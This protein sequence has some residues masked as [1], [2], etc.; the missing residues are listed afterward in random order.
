MVKKAKIE[1]GAILIFIMIIFL[2]LFFVTYPGDIEIV[3]DKTYGGLSNEDGW[4][5]LTNDGQGCL[6]AG[7]TESFG[8]GKKD[9]W[10]LK[11]D[12]NG[13]GIWN[14]TYG[15]EKS[16]TS[17]AIS[18][19]E[20]DSYLILGSTNSYGLEN[21][22]MWLIKI[23]EEGEEIWN[24]TYGNNGWEEGASIIQTEDEGYILVGSTSSYGAGSDDV[25]AIKI[26]S[27]GAEQWN[28]T[29]GGSQRDVGRSIDISEEGYAIGGT[30]SSYGAGQDDMWLIKIDKNGNEKWNKTFG[31]ENNERC[32]QVISTSNSIILVGHAIN[33]DNMWNAFVVNANLDGEQQW[34]KTIEKNEETGFSSCI[35]EENGYIIT[36]H[37]GSYGKQQ[38]LMLIYI[39]NS[40]NIIW[41]YI[42]DKDFGNAGV[43]IDN[44][45][46]SQFYVTG[47]SDNNGDESYDLWFLK[48]KI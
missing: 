19:A 25:W 1:I 7:Y 6:I 4:F 21:S 33:N 14:K 47:Y 35:E 26:D 16:D 45:Q 29:F 36:G 40:G 28:F 30:T 18:N 41:E 15:G 46:D 13:Q 38:D 24:K 10:I 32:N 27:Y 37:K 39:D 43:W 9:I 17:K 8:E 42:L 44:C 22:N 12:E 3:L 2:V 31:T 20:E 23:D 11:I 48:A 34:T 5:V